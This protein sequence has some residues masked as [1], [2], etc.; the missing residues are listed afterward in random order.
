MIATIVISNAAAQKAIPEQIR[1]ALTSEQKQIIS[2]LSGATAIDGNKILK[3]RWTSKEKRLARNYL[4]AN[5]ASIGIVAE[6]QVYKVDLPHRKASQN[7]FLGTNL[8]A[9]IPSSIPSDE[10]IVIGAHYDSVSESPGA[11]DN[12]TG[13]ALVYSVSKL[14][15]T[16]TDRKRNLVIVFFD[17]EET[18]HAGSY[19]FANYIK[20]RGFV[21]H[22]V[23]TADMVGWDSDGD[24][25][26]EIELPSP[27][28]ESIYRRHAS[29]FGV[30][31]YPTET[32]VTDHREF[33]NAGYNA[34]G[35]GGEYVNG[36]SSPHHHQPTD[37]V[38]TVDFDYLAFV[39]F[40]VYKV[41]EELI[42]G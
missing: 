9:I 34:I 7:P 29:S 42:A 16:L 15:S 18:G 23:H 8:F 21:V 1:L 36:D 32:S 6:E 5:L 4:K 27:D 20:E 13:C 3:R 25:N 10:Y 2:G 41:M 31:A 38:D 35:I 24:R 26:I 14:V 11:M 37:T 39:T 22:S 33:R 30:L 12:A 19:A 40:L 28:L 17:Q